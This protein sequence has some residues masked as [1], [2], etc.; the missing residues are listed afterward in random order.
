MCDKYE[1]IL[2]QSWLNQSDRALVGMDLEDCITQRNGMALAYA[3][4][5]ILY[6]LKD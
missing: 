1:N 3:S 2:S 6:T 5:H 4:E